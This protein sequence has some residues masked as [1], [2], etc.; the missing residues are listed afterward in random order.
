[1]RHIRTLAYSLAKPNGTRACKNLGEGPRDNF[2]YNNDEQL[3]NSN[4]TLRNSPKHLQEGTSELDLF[5]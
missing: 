3:L 4:N 1:M 5:S 2:C